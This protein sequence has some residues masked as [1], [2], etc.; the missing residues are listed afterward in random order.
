[1]RWYYYFCTLLMV[2]SAIKANDKVFFEPSLAQLDAIYNQP[3]LDPGLQAWQASA[4]KYRE[5]KIEGLRKIIQEPADSDC[6]NGQ[7]V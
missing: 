5:E 7:D 2:N 4:G 6:T 1:M 3:S